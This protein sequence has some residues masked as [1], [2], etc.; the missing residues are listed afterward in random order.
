MKQNNIFDKSVKYI[1]EQKNMSNIDDTIV[2][3]YYNENKKCSKNCG[4]DL[5]ILIIN[6]PCNGFG[7]IIYSMKIASYL[8]KWYNANIKI[9][10]TRIKQFIDLGQDKD[11]LIE[12][13]TKRTSQC[14]RL[15]SLEISK[16]TIFDL[17]FVAPSVEYSP[18]YYD[19][20]SVIPYSTVFNTYFFSEYNSYNTELYNFPTGVGNKLYGLLFDDRQIGNKL[21]VFK[22]PYALIYIAETI[23][24]AKRCYSSFIEMIIYKYNKKHTNFD[25]VLPSWIIDDKS[26]KKNIVKL[27]NDNYDTINIVYKDNI[28]TIKITDKN[29]KILN[30]RGDVLPVPYINMLSVI[31]YSIKDILVTGDQSITDVLS[32]CTLKNIFYQ[33]APWKEKF[34]K[35]L[36]IHLPNKYLLTKKT[37]CG[38][39]YAIKYNSNYRHFVDKW[40][41]RKLA[42]PKMDAIILAANARKTNKSIVE[43]EDI[44][45]NSRTLNSIKKKV[46]DITE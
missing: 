40:D 21:P 35:Q 28:Y 33:I 26:F 19:V 24:N 34:A 18:N 16:D 17:I 37:S 23:A 20:K 12:L 4:K 32:C 8:K 7:D 43:L 44:I 14:R 30:I 27:N 41:F 3:V 9:A 15:S 11:H 5:N 42:K 10:S 39:I 29:K 46:R 36:A 31:K 22:N 1:L 45:K 25:I 2:N 13:K 38:T 6:V